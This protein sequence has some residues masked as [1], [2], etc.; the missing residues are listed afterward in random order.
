MAKLIRE[1]LARKKNEHDSDRPES[2]GI[3]LDDLAR[4]YLEENPDMD[5]EQ[6]R[7]ELLGL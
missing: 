5:P 4:R 7:E 2:L 1:E 3:Y 6:L